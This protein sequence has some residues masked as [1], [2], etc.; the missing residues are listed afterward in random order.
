MFPNRKNLVKNLDH[1]VGYG[2]VNCAVICLWHKLFA[3]RKEATMS[4]K[5]GAGYGKVFVLFGALIVSIFASMDAPF[6]I[7]VLTVS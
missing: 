7:S 2:N 3:K 5:K 1:C 4:T 6:L